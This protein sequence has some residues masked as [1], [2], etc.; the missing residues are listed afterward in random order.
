FLLICA[1]A[2]VFAETATVKR[3][4]NLRSDPSTDNSPIAKLHKGD[5]V[6]L[7]EPDKTNGYYHVTT[8]AG[9]GFAWANNLS[10][11]STPPVSGG[12]AIPIGSCNNIQSLGDCPDSGCKKDKQTGALIQVNET[13]ALLN[14]FKRLVLPA[15]SPT[16]LI[17]NDFQQLQDA[18]TS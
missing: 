8:D 2:L 10:L 3:T 14:H 9:E 5:S 12:G 1:S 18:A 15:G 16:L 7:L 4:T 13:H 6:E 11:S 17:F